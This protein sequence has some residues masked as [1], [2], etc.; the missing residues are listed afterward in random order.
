MHTK[1]EEEIQ[2]KRYAQPHE[3]PSQTESLKATSYIDNAS[4]FSIQRNLSAAPLELFEDQGVSLTR[5]MSRFG[6]N[7]TQSS[8]KFSE[9]GKQVYEIEYTPSWRKETI[10]TQGFTS[11]TD[12]NQNINY[13][14][15]IPQSRINLL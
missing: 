10:G 11:I 7:F 12:F 14:N 4:A 13:V 15:N 3:L 5:N 9:E 1:K 8:E 6:D 2:P